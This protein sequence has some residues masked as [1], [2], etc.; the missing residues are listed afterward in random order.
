MTAPSQQE[1]VA[2]IALSVGA[3]LPYLPLLSLATIYVTDDYF[4]SDIFNGELAARALAGRIL[5]QGDVPVWT[6]QLCSGFPL[7]GAF[8]EPLGTLAF[9]L[10]PPAAALGTLVTAVVL[11]AAHGTYSLARRFGA[12]IAGAVLAGIAFSGSG[13]LASQLKHLSIVTTVVWLPIG[14]ICLDAAFGSRDTRDPWARRLTWAAAFG[15]VFAEQ[16]LA[17]F[18]QSAH[19]SAMVYGAFALFRTWTHRET[20]GYR[21]SL[22]LLSV[23]LLAIA[24]GAAAGAMVLV[25]LS[26]LGAVSDRSQSLGWEWATTLPYWPWNALTFLVPYINGDISDA[27]Y[28]GPSLFWEDY[29][30]VGAATFLLAIYGTVRDWRRAESRFLIALTVLAFL[31]VLGRHS[32]FYHWAYSFI[33][34]VS[35]FRFPTR[36]LVVV[37]L[38]LCVLAAI[39]ATR[40]RSDLG[41]RFALRPLAADAV[42]LGLCVFTAGDLAIHQSRQNPMVDAAT[43]LSPPESALHL[44]KYGSAART[45]TPHHTALHIRAFADARGWLN[46]QPYFVLRDLLQPNIGAAY[47]NIPSV[48]CYAGISPR[49]HVDIWGDHNRRG[50]VDRTLTT[51]DR[52]TLTFSALPAFDTLLRTF[53]VTHV[54]AQSP[55]AGMRSTPVRAG[56]AW[57][58]PVADAARARFVAAAR[59]VENDDHALS[60]II[61]GAFD[62]AREVLLHDGV[63]PRTRGTGSQG[64]TGR[65]AIASDT[66]R[67]VV[68]DVDA[69]E[70]GYLVLADT[71][72]PGWTASVDGR[73]T[74]IAR[75]NVAVRAVGVPAG[76]HRV[77]FEFEA[78]A[79]Y[80]GL[81]VTSVAGTVLLAAL[82]LGVWL[83]VRRRRA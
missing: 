58:Y 9:W 52:A 75:A 79:F 78:P 49:W 28:R 72:Y 57:V 22:A 55:I 21:T 81:L 39:G 65:T 11:V 76:R 54:L 3:L 27:T 66:P 67:R 17:G 36:F 68:V 38:G 83:D 80:R 44:A 53:A 15:A 63:L 24:L 32:V 34:G 41:T 4:T 33:P 74:E 71:F 35:Q 25:P 73:P 43:W 6:N 50:V 19:I 30:Y 16:V 31:M 10:L 62:P 61:S 37:D 12:S 60:H 77:V 29:G 82:A 45:Y 69:P 64:A 40:L 18:P 59:F 26:D 13:Y 23:L 47:W 46:V 7:P 1:V 20:L 56:T 42:G 51:P 48:D 5:R 70:D 8:G 14:L 2:R